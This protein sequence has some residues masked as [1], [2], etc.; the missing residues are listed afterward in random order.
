MWISCRVGNTRTIINSNSI[1]VIE[2]HGKEIKTLVDAADRKRLFTIGI[3]KDVDTASR[4][5]DM[6]E[7]AIIEKKEH[8]KM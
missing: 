7:V 4:K 2:Q 3:Y 5:M 1:T 6:F 8:F